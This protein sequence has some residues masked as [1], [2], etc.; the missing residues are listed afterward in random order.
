[1]VHPEVR[2]VL[3]DSPERFGGAFMAAKD[4]NAGRSVAMAFC[5]IKTGVNGDPQEVVFNPIEMK[6]VEVADG[7]D[8]HISGSWYQPRGNG[9]RGK[10]SFRYRPYLADLK[11]QLEF[12]E[13]DVPWGQNF[14][15]L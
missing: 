6:R 13:G 4:A 3:V 2:L 1:M 7:T 8:Y 10:L 9:A 15:R 14:T 5:H 12:Q 11:K